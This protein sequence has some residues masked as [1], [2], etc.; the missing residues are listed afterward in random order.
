[1]VVHVAAVV[2]LFSLP[3]GLFEPPPRTAEVQITPLIEPLTELTQNAPTKGKINKEFDATELHPRPRIQI[4]MGLPSTTT[5]PGSQPK[6]APPLP[7]PPKIEAAVKEMPKTELPHAAAPD[8][9]GGNPQAGV[10]NPQPPPPPA[11]PRAGPCARAGHVGIRRH[12]P[13]RS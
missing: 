3:K 8:S 4:P 10:R 9:A 1:M 6:P 11:S 2:T 7:E 13:G 12:S 5:P